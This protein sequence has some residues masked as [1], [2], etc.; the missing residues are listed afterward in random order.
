M[1]RYNDVYNR[2]SHVAVKLYNE[3][4]KFELMQEDLI[5]ISLN[6]DDICITGANYLVSNKELEENEKYYTKVY[7]K[8]NSYIYKTTCSN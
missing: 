4:T 8:Y 5:L 2:Y 7:D 1:E 3:K 6:Y